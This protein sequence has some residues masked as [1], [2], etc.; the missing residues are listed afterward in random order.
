MSIRRLARLGLIALLFPLTLTAANQG[1]SAHPGP[2]ARTGLRPPPPRP[3]VA[4]PAAWALPP[5]AGPR[6]ADLLADDPDTAILLLIAALGDAPVNDNFADATVIVTP[7]GDYPGFPVMGDNLGATK[8]TGEPNHGGNA[9]GKSAWWKWTAPSNVRVSLYSVNSDFETVLGV[10]TGSAVNALTAVPA[11]GFTV[12]VPE[13]HFFPATA[14]STYYI[15]VDGLDG[16]S[17]NII[18]NLATLAATPPVITSQPEDIAVDAG[19]N[20]YPIL[21][22]TTTGSGPLSYQWFHDGIRIDHADSASLLVFHVGA[23]EAG[24]YHVVVA[25]SWGSVTSATAMVTVR[26][27]T[28]PVITSFPGDQYVVPGGGVTFRVEA[29]GA[30]PLSYQWLFNGAPIPGATGATLSLTKAQD[31]DLGDYAVIVSNGSGSVTSKSLELKLLPGAFPPTI[32]TQPVG[33]TVTAGTNVVLSV[34]ATSLAPMTYQWF[35]NSTLLGAATSEVLTLN[36]AQAAIAGSYFV[37]VMNPFGTTKSEVVTLTVNPIVTPPTTTPSTGGG[38]GG[39]APSG[40][41]I[42]ALSALAGLKGIK[43]AGAPR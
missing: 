17:G 21:S 31:S 35:H 29:T 16:R 12:P 7:A 8:E 22:V 4:E 34:T 5:A 33:Q 36:S 41:F 38:G 43:R 32:T 27:D 10:Y 18:V 26:V 24:A 20:P 6:A 25:N 19:N 9:G 15:A 28:R 42:A 14:G 2:G 30:G 3:F 39:G 37:N 11:D 13:A 40:W 1:S 23:A